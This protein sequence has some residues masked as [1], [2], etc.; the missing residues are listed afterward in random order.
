MALNFTTNIENDFSTTNLFKENSVNNYIKEISKYKS[1]TAEEEQEFARRA[2]E[3]SKTA[4]QE[5]IRAN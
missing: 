1:L 4:K 2:K 3:G 5:L